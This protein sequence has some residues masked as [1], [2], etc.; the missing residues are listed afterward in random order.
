MKNIDLS[1]LKAY[2]KEIEELIRQ[3]KIYM[4]RENNICNEETLDLIANLKEKE[5]RDIIIK[6]Q[7]RIINKKVKKKEI[8]DHYKIILNIVKDIENKISSDFQY[9]RNM[10]ENR[11]N[12]NIN[13]INLY[14]EKKFA[15][16]TEFSDYLVFKFNEIIS[17]MEIIIKSYKLLNKQIINFNEENSHL[18]KKLKQINEIN[19][20]LCFDY[21]IKERNKF[22]TESSFEK[23]SQKLIFYKKLKNI[24]SKKFNDRKNKKTNLFN[25]NTF[26][27]NDINNG[28][29]YYTSNNIN[30]LTNKT[31]NKNSLIL[32]SS[33]CLSTSNIS[34]INKEK[35]KEKKELNYIDKLTIILYYNI[36]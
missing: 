8:Y 28:Q 3:K 31:T 9:Y 19:N 25:N 14:Y 24:S 30:L 13:E 22:I 4:E 12:S 2:K 21:K 16:T 7:K 23:K 29:T 10:T 11:I 34:N 27:N 36:K 18:K 26:L 15:K 6:L 20:K 1:Q 35:S 5:Y 17:K 32:F 33:N